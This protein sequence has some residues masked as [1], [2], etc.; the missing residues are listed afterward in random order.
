[1][2]GQ[3]PGAETIDKLWKNLKNEVCSISEIPKDRWDIDRF[4]DSD[5]S[6]EEYSYSKIV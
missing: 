5:P 2:S 1:M 3:F 6:K 4:Y